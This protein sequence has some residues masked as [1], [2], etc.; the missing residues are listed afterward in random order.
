SRDVGDSYR[1]G[2]LLSNLGEVYWR[3]GRLQQGI[4][5]LE[6]SLAICRAIGDRRGIS[7]TLCNLAEVNR[8]QGRLKEAIE[9]YGE[10]LGIGRE[11]GDLWHEARALQF[12]GVALQRSED[13]DAARG[14][15]QEALTIFSRLGE[16]EAE[17]VRAY[18][19]GLPNTTLKEIEK[20]P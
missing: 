6:R 3:L 5:C 1:Q 12:L 14:C 10:A 18:L 19:L 16:P 9:L 4:E 20:A 2:H 17:E 8:N 11:I 15:W 7:L 13:A